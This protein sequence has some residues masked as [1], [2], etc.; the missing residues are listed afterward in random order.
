MINLK[1]L[2]VDDNPFIRDGIQL[3]L[4]KGN[5][6]KSIDNASNGLEAFNLIK[7]ND[8][9]I[10]LM[11]ISMPIMNGKEAIQKIMEIKP[12]LKILVVSMHSTKDEIEV[13]KEYGAKGYI[14][15]D[16]VSRDL[17]KVITRIVNNEL[18][19]DLVYY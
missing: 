7:E 19:F 1:L 14:L 12:Y 10:V 15:K 13:L 17:V 9:D 2:I 5:W 6:Q 18:V 8:Y 4:R 3:T 11:D 16:D